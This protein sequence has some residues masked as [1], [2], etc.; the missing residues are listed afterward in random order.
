MNQVMDFIRK[1][2]SSEGYN[3]NT[4]H[5]IHGKVMDGGK[6]EMCV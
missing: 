2:R 4:V 6:E 1:E 5:A 3:P